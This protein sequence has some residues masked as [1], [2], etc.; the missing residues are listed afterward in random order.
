[1]QNYV[2][3]YLLLIYM[4]IV[5]HSFLMELSHNPKNQNEV[6]SNRRRNQPQTQKWMYDL[7]S[8]FHITLRLFSYRSQL[9][10]KCGK[11][12]NKWHTRR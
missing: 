3:V 6:L 9:T 8:T 5:S 1:M 10:L 2:V 12:K 11:N 4:P 7:T